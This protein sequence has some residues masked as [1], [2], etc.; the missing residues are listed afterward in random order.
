[1]KSTIALLMIIFSVSCLLVNCTDSKNE[2]PGAKEA[3]G[4]FESQVKWGEHLVTISACHDCHTPK[5]FNKMSPWGPD[6]DSN[7]LL[8]GYSG[9]PVPDLNRKEIQDKGYGVTNGDLTAWIG[10]W[11]VSFTANLT[12]D[13]TGIGAWKEEQFILAMREG[14]FKGLATNRG[15]LPP[16]P[17]HMYR[18]MTDDELKAIFA[19]LKSTKPVKNVVPPPQPPVQ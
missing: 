18:H 9:I 4:G 13:S 12:S 6:L 19:Y 15:L 5:D 14:K 2:R 1:M 8:A 16:M 11:G 7:R 3:Y 17:W 10:P